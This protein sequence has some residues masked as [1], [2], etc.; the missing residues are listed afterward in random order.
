[1]DSTRIF[2]HVLAL[3]LVASATAS[4]GGNLPCVQQAVDFINSST[5]TSLHTV[6]ATAVSMHGSAV[7]AYL[8]S[9]VT[10]SSCYS[11]TSHTFQPCLES[12][13]VPA[14]L[15]NTATQ[16]FDIHHPLSMG[17]NWISASTL[18]PSEIASM[19]ATYDFAGTCTAGN[20]MLIGNDQWGN[21]WTI[22]FTLTAGSPPPR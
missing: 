4:A 22:A 18:V 6:T 2:K 21:H 19:S 13:F 7:A 12:A 16:P 11:S 17:F 8:T 15:S 20:T 10:V 9:P 14:L 1:M 3:S 5:P